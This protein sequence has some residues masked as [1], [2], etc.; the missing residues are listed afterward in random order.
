MIVSYLETALLRAVWYPTTVATRSWHLK[1]IIDAAWRET[2]DAPLERM[3]FALHDFGARGALSSESASIGGLAH[4]VNFRGLGY[5]LGVARRGALYHEPWRDFVGP[6]RRTFGTITSG[7]VSATD[8]V[9]RNM[10]AQFRQEPGDRF[11]VS[12]SYDVCR[13]TAQTVGRPSS[14]RQLLNS[15][16]MLVVRPTPAIRPDIVL[17]SSES[18][19]RRSVPR[20]TPRA[21]RA[22]GLR[23]RD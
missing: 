11:V 1:T 7:A 8:A 5:A 18:S 22:A 9:L 17:K 14:K 3:V 20:L 12:D 10:L 23:P 6:G 13:A 21:A 16:G 19:M 2:S 15:G 4:L